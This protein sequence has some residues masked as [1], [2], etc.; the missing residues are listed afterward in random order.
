[1]IEQDRKEAFEYIEGQL[2]NGYLDLGF[3]DKNEI[4]IVK[5]AI[6]VLK[7]VDK[8]NSIGCT[9]FAIIPTQEK[10]IK[11]SFEDEPE[12]KVID[13]DHIEIKEKLSGIKAEKII[14]DIF[15]T[16][17]IAAYDCGDMSNEEIESVNPLNGYYNPPFEL[18]EKSGQIVYKK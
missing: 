1:M 11:V 12:V 15:G 7:M 4:E 18:D 14:S 2:R 8:F 16:T 5:E 3:H 13:C 17:D 9:S 10:P 6:D